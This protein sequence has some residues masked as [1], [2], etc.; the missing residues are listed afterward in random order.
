MD[1]LP[2]IAQSPRVL[3]D[4]MAA[5]T[6]RG[7]RPRLDSYISTKQPQ[8]L[9]SLLP[10][11]L[12]IPAAAGSSTSTYNLPLITSLVVYVGAQAIVQLQGK[13]PLQNSPAMD[14]FKQL[15]ASFDSEGRYHL[16]N[17]MANQLRY[18]NRCPLFPVLS[19]HVLSHTVERS[20]CGMRFSCLTCC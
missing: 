18:P 17:A 6:E 8:D 4:Y 2:E 11:A 14:I 7:I 15:V 13:I 12:I 1:L 19:F 5:L 3:T 20:S 10:S 16:F 9:P